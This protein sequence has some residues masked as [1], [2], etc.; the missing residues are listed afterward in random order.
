MGF[1]NRRLTRALLLNGHHRAAPLAWAKEHRGWSVEDW[2]RV[3]WSEESRFRLKADGRL[4]VWRHAHE[5][6]DPAGQVGTV[7][8]HGGSIMVWSVFSWHCLGS[9]ERVS[10]SFNAIQYVELLGDSLRP[11]M[12]LCY[13]HG[14]GVFQQDNCTSHK[15]RLATGWL[16]KL[17][18]DFS[19]IN[20]LPR[21]LDFNPV[22]HLWGVWEHGVKCHHTAPTNLSE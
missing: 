19:V 10:T 3:V 4:R 12:L 8:G 11:F 22:E 17:T 9:L 21:S 5:V 16:N 15:S 2:K 20:W 1:G 13:S 6:M 7:Q 18:S 14:N